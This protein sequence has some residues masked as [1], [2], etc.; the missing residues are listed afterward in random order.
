MLC[1]R[2]SV[3]HIGRHIYENEKISKKCEN[4]FFFFLFS[5]L[6]NKSERMAQGKPQVKFEGNTC[7]IFRDNCH[8][9]DVG[10]LTNFDFVS[11]VDNQAE[12]K[13][14]TSMSIVDDDT[15]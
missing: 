11:S 9:D 4:V 14:M 15:I 1:R 10:R 7:I 2:S 3:A 6:D 13:Y 8:T 5:K 12:L